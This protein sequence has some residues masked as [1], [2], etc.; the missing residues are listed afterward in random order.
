MD[1]DGGGG[2]AKSAFEGDKR[3]NVGA[4]NLNAEH[5]SLRRHSM[6]KDRRRGEI[7]VQNVGDLGGGQ[8]G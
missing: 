2:K 4:R 5:P 6:E 8:G 7:E 1:A 3:R